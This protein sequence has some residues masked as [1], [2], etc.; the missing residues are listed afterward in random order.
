[1]CREAKKVPLWTLAVCVVLV[2]ALPVKRNGVGARKGIMLNKL[3][4]GLALKFPHHC[5]RHHFC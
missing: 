4:A 3:R 2:A 1:M 5:G